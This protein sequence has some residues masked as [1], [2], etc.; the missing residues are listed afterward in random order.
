MPLEYTLPCHR[1]IARRHP[2]AERFMLT[3]FATGKKMVQAEALLAPCGLIDRSVESIRLPLQ[4]ARRISP[5]CCA[6]CVK[7]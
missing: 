4:Q 5:N 2:D 6:S 7:R 3:N 1:D